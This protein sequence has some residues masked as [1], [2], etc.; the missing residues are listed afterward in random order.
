MGRLGVTYEQ[1]SEAASQV[2]T[3][4]QFPTI[5]KVRAV[6]GVGSNTTLNVYMNRW[7][8]E[9]I[10]NHLAGTKSTALPDPVQRVIKDIWEALR[11]ESNIANEHVQ[12]EATV[13]VKQAQQAKAEAEQQANTLQEQL[14]KAQLKINHLETD[15]QLVRSELIEQKQ[16]RAVFQERAQRSEQRFEDLKQSTEMRL[17]ELEQSHQET[18]NHLQKQLETHEKNFKQEM[19]ELKTYAENQRHKLIAEIDQLRVAKEKAEKAHLQ[20][21]TEL[22]NQLETNKVLTEQIK[23]RDTDV[24]VLKQQYNDGEKQQAFLHAQA[25]QKECF[26]AELKE[27]LAKTQAKLGEAREYIGELKIISKTHKIRSLDS[28]A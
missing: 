12:Q 18:V 27:Q 1:F 22:K 21:A 20:G 11:T 25:A 17:T 4:G 28:K 16:E 9:F 5:E 14:E 2:L 19:S 3:T 26:L 10:K 24:K 7:K 13:I 23:F 6:I 8:D 15:L